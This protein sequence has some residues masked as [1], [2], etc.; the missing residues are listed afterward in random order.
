[1]NIEAG[2]YDIYAGF[3]QHLRLWGISLTVGYDPADEELGWGW[4]ITLEAQFGPWS[5]NAGLW[6]DPVR[7]P[8]AL[9]TSL[10]G[11]LPHNRVDEHEVGA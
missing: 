6:R 8:G 10:E 4:E 7:G 1:M 9:A 5:F 3:D 2:R 11:I